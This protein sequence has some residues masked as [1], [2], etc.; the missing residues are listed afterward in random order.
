[1][2]MDMD[3]FYAQVD[4]ERFPAWV[5]QPIAVVQTGVLCVTSNYRIRMRG[6]KKI[7]EVKPLQTLIPHTK[8]SA[9]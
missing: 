1:M 7:G 5:G 9:R 8:F 6:A 4:R 3:C 2:H